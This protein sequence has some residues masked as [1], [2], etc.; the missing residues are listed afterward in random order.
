MNELEELQKQIAELQRKAQVIIDGKRI[1]ALEVTRN[2]IRQYEFTAQ[3]LGLGA[4]S[5]KA[6]KGK[7]PI[8]Y[9]DTATGHEWD[10]ELHQKGRKPEWIKEKQADGTIEQFRVK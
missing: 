5:K 4:Q 1:E 6:P 9:R 2:N 3:E 7:K 10:G 8:T